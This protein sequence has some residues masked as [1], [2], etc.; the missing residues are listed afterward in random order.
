MR[1][2][3]LVWLP[4]VLAICLASFASGYPST[5]PAP[6][7][8]PV[9]G[10]DTARLS[11]FL[12]ART[13]PLPPAPPPAVAEERA[14]RQREKILDELVFRGVP[15]AWRYGSLKVQ[16]GEV[17]P[18]TDGFVL[19]RLKYEA[20]PGMWIPA[21]LYL[22]AGPLSRR[23]AVLN[24]NGHVGAPGKATPYEQIRCANLAR[25]GIVS[26]HPEW[27]ACGELSSPEYAH[28]RLAYLDLCGVS[29]VSVFYLA[30]RRGLDV[31]AAHA[32]VDPN[33]IGMTGLSGGGWQTIWLSALDLRVSAT[34][35]NAGYVGMDVRYGHPGDIGDLEQCPQDLLTVT[36]YPALTTL[37][38]PRPSLL[39]YNQR[40]DCCFQT[41]RVIPS[42]VD[43][44]RP[45]FRSRGAADRFELHNNIDPGTHN[46]DA[47][48]RSQFY[49]FASRRLTSG[50]GALVETSR[51]GD[52]QPESALKCGVPEGNAGF[53]G[54]AL[55]FAESL[56]L[57]TLP[58]PARMTR[59][60]KRDA[61]KRL[62]GAIRLDSALAQP[63]RVTERWEPNRLTVS[64]SAFPS[65]QAEWAPIERVRRI[66]LRLWD[67]RPASAPLSDEAGTLTAN[68]RLL[69]RGAPGLAGGALY[70]QA[71]LV[72][73]TG[74]RPLGVQ[75]RQLRAMCAALRRAHPSAKLEIVCEGPAT[76]LTALIAVSL[77]EVAVDR[78]EL[79]RLPESLKQLIRDRA[80]FEALPEAFCF[81]LLREIDIPEL[82][83]LALPTRI[84]T[85]SR[86]GTARGL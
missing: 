68:G 72:A 34:A 1:T 69:L 50:D 70:Q 14:V 51:P 31:L 26:L 8:A 71:M 32:A 79:N 52:V 83:G 85:A 36:D 18:G 58:D 22:P 42:V 39:I 29:G 5:G 47:D 17:V 37:L 62:A 20:V 33:R 84:E 41:A 67:V 56:P 73:A 44:V 43:P 55:R 38:A 48:N 11:A 10:A 21:L 9:S 7:P 16:W 66:R 59:R 80:S 2:R 12:R 35:P 74:E 65:A 78:L 86:S 27:L 40:D 75:V 61:R 82:R 15:P 53:A 19:R 81:G 45:Y 60:W 28:N 54:L 23:P 4:G 13:P 25:Q 63:D 3:D 6:A 49:R 76:S 30:M 57:H 24:V 64:S 77:G 46:Y